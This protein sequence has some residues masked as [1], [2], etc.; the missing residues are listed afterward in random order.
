MSGRARLSGKN[1][2]LS[3]YSRRDLQRRSYLIQS[4]TPALKR[5]LVNWSNFKIRMAWPA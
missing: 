1:D 4:S 5:R 2:L 3:L